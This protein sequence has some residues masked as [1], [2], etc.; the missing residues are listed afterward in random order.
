MFHERPEHRDQLQSCEDP[1]QELLRT[2]GMLGDSV[3]VALLL[4]DR[5][6]PLARDKHH[7]VLTQNPSTRDLAEAVDEMA[8]GWGPQ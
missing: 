5:I 1:Q 7:P 4:P 8:R 2:A 3:A 6:R